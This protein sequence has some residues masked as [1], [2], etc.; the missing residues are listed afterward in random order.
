MKRGVRFLGGVAVCSVAAV[1]AAPAMAQTAAALETAQTAA[2][3]ETAQAA[4]APEDPAASAAIQDGSAGSA[5]PAQE[6]VVTGIRGSI[7]RALQIK[8]NSVNV[9]DSITME[10]LG[11]LPDQNVA[12]SLQRIPG[13]T[14]E[15]NRGDG[16]FI[17]VRG[18]GPD[19]N[20][21]TLNGR[22]L[23]TD[24]VGRAFSFDVLPSELIAGA[25][26]Y[27]SPTAAINGAS[28]GATVNIRTVRPLDQAEHVVAASARAD[29]N[30]LRGAFSPDLST[31]ISLR[32]AEGTFGVALAASYVNRR[33]RDDEFTIGA[34]HVKRS[35]TPG[36]YFAGRLGPGVAPFENID[37][38]SN[39]SPFFVLS[40]KERLGLSATVQ[41]KPTD[42]LLLTLDGLYTHLDQLDNY[43]GVA[44]DFSGGTLVDQVLDGDKAV[45]QKIEGGFVDEIIQRTP[46]KS[47][48]YMVGFNADWNKGP[49]DVVLDAS[50]S[51]NDLNGWRGNFFTTI[52]RTGM[53]M[54]Y[55]RRS[56]SPIYDYDFSSPDYP[57]A[58][59]DVDHIGAHY[60]IDGGDLRTDDTA[61]VK[62][63][64]SY[65]VSDALKLSAGASRQAR[66]KR[67]RSYAQ[68]FGGQ[69]A[70]CGGHVYYPLPSDIFHPTDMDFFSKYK[71][72]N[73]VRDWIGYNPFD[74]I[75]LLQAY[76][77]PDGRS[78]YE[79]PTYSPSR[80]S[81]VTEDV[82]LGYVMADWNSEVGGMPL[83][84]N[85][86][87]RIEDTRF[88][89][90]GAAQ[91]IISAKPNGL[92][93][94][95]IEVS[96]VVP[97]AFSGHYTDY[98][99]SV[100][101]RLDLTDTLLLRFAASKVM[102]R[103]TLSDLS[104]A[105]SIQTNPGNETI[106]RGNPNLL[107]FRA[108]Q[109]E[110]GLEWYFQRLGLLSATAFY[111]D[112]ESFVSLTTSPQQV[113][114]VTFQVTQP[115]NGKG[116]KVKG[117]EIGY[118][119]AFTF[120]PGVLSGLG[121][122]ASYTYVDST[123]HY[124]NAVTGV[125]YGLEGLSPNSYTLVGF[126]EKGP[127]QARLAYTWRDRF[128]QV[129]NGRNG[130][131]E[132]FDAYGQLDASVSYA[133]TD[134]LTL[135]VDAL[136]LTD[137]NEFIYSTTPDRTKEYRTTGRRYTF[138]VRARF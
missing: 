117:F 57:N 26:I 63:A 95:I 76:R 24:N 91:T 106:R 64:A 128:L 77:T 48:T 134:N 10:D 79:S 45:Y 78:L 66:N 116:A 62:L 18:L 84:V 8:R 28:I 131:P 11:K 47:D 59:T 54:E 39:L 98:L 2:A 14:I 6:I 50:Y 35:S 65:K 132:Y 125:S 83:T 5:Q 122:E 108:K 25:D 96:P 33:S 38:P 70:F 56:G 27:K 49:L 12:E 17:S 58:P 52:R 115:T 136:N 94:N 81:L 135:M 137:S 73:I 121:A 87:L 42:N 99:P 15:R 37:M 75:H 53:T 43:T 100:N 82:W 123:A 20:A 40:D 86:G 31:L 7:S 112:I 101:V 92:G 138:G 127:A 74:L 97:I 1:C 67:Q 41:V 32:N 61:E 103:P 13:V 93:Q 109:A 55:D 9:V 72:D 133:I 68:S 124:E 90:S 51:R 30:E 118:R 44:F 46:R 114:Q 120:L 29:Y 60:F 107:P 119:Q 102:T 3:L 34:G 19:F 129:A 4:P 85:A 111:K 36:G 126:Y 22:T 23:A 105:Q 130:D 89:S 113:D 69:C 21:V 104:P 80:S 16:Q 88:T 110:I 71:S